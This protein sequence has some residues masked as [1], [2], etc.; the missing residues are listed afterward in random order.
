MNILD[1]PEWL[2][3][4]LITVFVIITSI[5]SV[6]AVLSNCR[7]SMNSTTNQSQTSQS[8]ISIPGLD[9]IVGRNQ[10]TKQ[11]LKTSKGYTD[12]TKQ[13]GFVQMQL[14]HLYNTIAAKKTLD[15][16]EKANLIHKLKEKID[17]AQE[18]EDTKEVDIENML[19]DIANISSD[20]LEDINFTYCTI[21]QQLETL[22]TN[23]SVNYNEPFRD[24]LNQIQERDRKTDAYQKQLQKENEI[25]KAEIKKGQKETQKLREDIQKERQETNVYREELRKQKQKQQKETNTY[26]Q[27]LLDMQHETQELNDMHHMNL[28]E[29]QQIMLNGQKKYES[30]ISE[31]SVQCKKQNK[32]STIYCPLNAIIHTL[33]YEE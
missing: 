13:L 33:L 1:V 20:I 22:V 26:R 12:D 11:L 29:Q 32:E 10:R 17:A 6:F 31:L 15:L 3:A 23:T 24:I 19:C 14:D 27:R 4:A 16:Q 21:H 9:E 25:C 8:N 2:P 7:T 5:R 28:F 30:K 18:N